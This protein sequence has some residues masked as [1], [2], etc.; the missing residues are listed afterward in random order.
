MKRTRTQFV[1]GRAH[2]VQLLRADVR[3]IREAKVNE[4]P[5]SEK[6]LVGEGFALVSGEAEGT[7]NVW[8]ANLLVLEFL[9][10]L[11]NVSS[12]YDRKS[13]IVHARFCSC[14][15]CFS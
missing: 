10:C 2:L 7:P 11:G 3:A 5:F 4:A 14:S 9:L 15:F 8:S 13:C 6:I 1:Y 12:S